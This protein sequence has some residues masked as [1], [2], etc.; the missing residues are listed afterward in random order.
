M[1]TL[2]DFSIIYLCVFS[3]VTKELKIR[4]KSF[5]KAENAR[6]KRKTARAAIRQLILSKYGFAKVP[7]GISE[8]SD[9]RLIIPEVLGALAAAT[10]AIS[11]GGRPSPVNVP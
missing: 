10:G 4:T 8:L 6:V 11:P 2:C 3:A 7:F 9:R 1:S 5:R